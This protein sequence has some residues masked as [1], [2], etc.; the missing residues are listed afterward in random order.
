[1]D[2]LEQMFETQKKLQERLCTFEKMKD[3]KDKVDFIKQNI[4]AVIEEATEIL[5]CTPYKNPNYCK[6]GW[7]KTQLWDLDNY[8][9]EIVDLFHFL[10]NLCIAVDM[11]T[12]EFFNIYIKKNNKNHDRQN[13]GY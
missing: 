9:E 3:E 12:D 1:M 10:M 7:K 5:R 6:F 2:R 13:G 4:I 11:S 8:K